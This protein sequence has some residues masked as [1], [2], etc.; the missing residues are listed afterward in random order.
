MIFRDVCILFANYKL[1]DLNL[2]LKLSITFTVE[3]SGPDFINRVT[4]FFREY[5]FIKK[6]L[7]V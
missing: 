3:I 4:V 1:L 6:D 5:I 7:P 2:I